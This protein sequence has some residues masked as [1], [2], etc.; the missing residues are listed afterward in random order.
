[1]NPAF[2]VTV[3]GPVLGGLGW[4]LEIS[5]LFWL[6]VA[7]AAITLFLNLASGVMKLP[8]LPVIFMVVA[9]VLLS[10]WYVGLGVG[11]LIWTALEAVGKIVGLKAEGRL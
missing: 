3:A 10:P 5:W 4:Y 2:L 9:A 7:F 8:V 11:L 1:M 6:G